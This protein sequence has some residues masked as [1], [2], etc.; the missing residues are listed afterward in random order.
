MPGQNVDRYTA[1][2]ALT[3]TLVDAGVSY[4]FINTGTDYPPIIESW[5]KYEQKGLPKPKI[6]ICPHEMVALSAAQG[7][8]QATGKAQAVFVHVDVG[9]QNLGGS[10]HNAYR[11]RV[12]AFILAGVSPITIEGE[13]K[14]TRTSPIQFLQNV[15]D[16]AGIVREYTKWYYELRT[17]KNIQQVVCRGL[18][19]AHSDP[20]GPVYMM[21][22]R[23]LLE[24]EITPHK[25]D[26]RRWGAIKKSGLAEDSVEQI[27][28][29]LLGAKKPVMITSYLGRNP[30][31]VAELV[32]LSERLAIPV[33]EVFAQFMNFPA[34]HPLHGGCKPQAAIAEADLILIID[35]DLPWIPVQAAPNPN[36]EV[37]YLDVDPLKE[38]TPLWYIPADG[39]FKADSYEALK[40]INRK[41]DTVKLPDPSLLADRRKAAEAAHRKR[42]LTLRGAE[43]MQEVLTPEFIA[44]T[45]NEVLGDDDIILDETTSYQ[46]LLE[47]HI[48]RNKPGTKFMSGGSA[49]GWFGG[50]AIGV[51]LANPGKNVIALTGDG[52]Y[53]F[54]VPTA[55][56][57]VAGKYKTP[58]MTV[59]FNNQGWGAA[60]LAAIREHPEGYA[61]SNDTF[62]TSINPPAELE[63]V[64]RAAGGAFT[65]VVTKPEALKKALLEG[66]EATQQGR[67]AVINMILP[68]ISGQAT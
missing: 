18:Q 10:I 67:C 56:Y 36:A 44:A 13:L 23:E 50:A 8:A 1:A 16:Q 26:I 22:A 31:C 11:C 30:Q 45:L 64:A 15:H 14:G 12:P 9:T 35:S 25:P 52:T 29:A 17:G 51:K 47:Q 58:F 20:Q 49:L 57:W 68:P 19:I 61:V 4:I 3:D 48:H 39:Y 6:I 60:Q 5:A 43:Q 21:A 54:S 24:E 46:P 2:D 38:N 7:Y 37:L 40:Q 55:A 59:I 33:V 65:R 28:N 66:L 63:Q 41:L 62:W 42:M 34:K 27:S 32:K 53:I